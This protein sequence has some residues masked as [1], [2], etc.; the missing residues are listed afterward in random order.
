MAITMTLDVI[1]ICQ[2]VAPGSG[3]SGSGSMAAA[4]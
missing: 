1:V 4:S 3:F 2:F